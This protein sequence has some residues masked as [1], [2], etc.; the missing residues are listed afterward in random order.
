[1][2]DREQWIPNPSLLVPHHDEL[3]CLH[4]HGEGTVCSRSKSANTIVSL[5]QSLPDV[6]GSLIVR[7]SINRL[8]IRLPTLHHCIP[9]RMGDKYTSCRILHDIAVIRYQR[10][11]AKSCQGRNNVVVPGAPPRG[12][13][14]NYWDLEEETN[15]FR[16]KYDRIFAKSYRYSAQMDVLREEFL[17]T[18]LDYILYGHRGEGYTFKPVAHL[19]TIS[20]YI[21][22]LF[23]AKYHQEFDT[24][25]SSFIKTHFPSGLLPRAAGDD[26]RL[27]GDTYINFI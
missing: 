19:K 16:E 6:I 2:G 24:S 9:L 18:I 27:P 26:A 7:A 17:H 13:A 3:I 1:M 4:S 22:K 8:I 11:L 5:L 10:I 12:L 15:C 20:Q 14:R 25:L 21:H 23:R